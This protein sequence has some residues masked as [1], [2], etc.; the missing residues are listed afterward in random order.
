MPRSI[1]SQGEIDA[2][3]QGSAAK[4]RSDAFLNVLK[5]AFFSA[6]AHLDRPLAEAAV[7]GPYVE[8]LEH[9]LAQVVS[10]TAFVVAAELG[11]HELLL[12]VPA[13]DLDKLAQELADTTLETVEHMAQAWVSYL[14]GTLG[15]AY[16]VYK[17]QKVYLAGLPV[18]AGA[19]HLVRCFLQSDQERLEFC[20]LIQNFSALELLAEQ[21]GSTP[22]LRPAKQGAKKGQLIK[23]PEFAVSTA[24]FT[25]IGELSEV[26]TEQGL[27]LLED[28]DLTITVELGRTTLTLSEILE[29]KPQ[30]VVKLEKIA[31]E[32]VD[33][34]VNNNRVAKG[35]VVV[36]D[37]NF[38]VRILE[39][40]PKS[41]RVRE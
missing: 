31:G 37:E 6:L 21:L 41:Q 25:P 40:I 36:L 2:L 9:S 29:L 7:D 15:V 14:A 5:Q 28:I 23:G 13:H 27:S 10:S 20:V 39:I 30:S 8:R 1:L 16:T 22:G 26:P 19:N 3:L 24:V 35:E 33:V 17:G 11:S 38:G 32:P 18:P 4:P 34:Y 12:L